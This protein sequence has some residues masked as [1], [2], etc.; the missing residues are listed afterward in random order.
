MH[1]DIHDCDDGDD[2]EDCAN[3]NG[4]GHGYDDGSGRV[5]WYLTLIK[6]ELLSGGGDQEKPA[7]RRGSAMICRPE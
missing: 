1:C 2:A 6:K 7:R 4:H 3:E 5:L